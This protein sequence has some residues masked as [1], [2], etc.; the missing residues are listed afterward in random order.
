M[1]NISKFYPQLLAVLGFVI[2]ALIYFYPVLQHN[3]AFYQ[4]DI[5]QYTGMAKE[6]NDFR[7]ATGEE[8]YWTN[9]AFG[10]MPT[11][12]MGAKY[13]HNYIKAID[14]VIRFLPRPAD[15]LF[16][17]FLG[18]FILL[19]VLKVD[20]LKAFFGALAFGLSTYLIVI[21]G[22]GHNAKAHTIAYMPLVLAGI[23]LVFRKRYIA[24]GLLT[25]LATALEINA[26]HFQMTY[27]LLFLLFFVGLYFVI[28]IVKKQEYRH[29][30]IS[31]GVFAIAGIVALGLN[32]T[33]LMAT[34]EYTNYSIRGKSELT[35]KPDNKPVTSDA[36]MDYDYI[37]Q[38][39][40]GKAESFNLLVP[41]LFGG[42]SNETG[43]KN[44][45]VYEFFTG[46]VENPAD[47]ASYAEK[48]PSYWGDQPI[49][50]APAY[51]GIVVFF[52]AVFALFADKRKIKYAFLAGA[53]LT[54]LLSW[55][56]N[57]SGLTEFFINYVP[58]YDK[59]RAVSSIQVIVELCA[60]ILA[61]MGLQTFFKIEDKKQQFTYLWQSALVVVVILLGLYAFKGTFNFEGARDA[62][63][64]RSIFGEQFQR[65][66]PG[67]LEALKQDRIAMYTGDIWRSLLYT[68][69]A[70]LVLWLFTKQK[71]TE[72]IAVVLVGVLIV[73]DLFTF[74]RNYVNA[75][76]FVSARKMEE[77]FEITPADAQIMADTTHYRVYDP[78]A[79]QQARTSYFHQAVGG[80]SAVRPRREDELFTYSFE[81]GTNEDFE[82]IFKNIDEQ[83]ISL[84]APVPV[85]DLL[86]VKYLL[87][88][89]NDGYV[90]ITNPN[91]AGP[92]WFVSSVKPVAS[93][94]EELKA[95]LKLDVKN[96]AVINNEKFPEGV[97]ETT[98]VQ[99]STATITLNSY[100]PNDLEYTSDNKN[101]GLAVFSEMY[102]AKGWN[103]Y[104]DGKLTPHYQADYT[105]RAL[106]VPA[107]KHKIQFKFEPQVVK[108]GSTITLISFI[109]FLALLGAGV[110]FERKKSQSQLA[111]NSK[112]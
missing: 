20:T 101:K 41:R 29:L 79:R 46:L 78:F 59:F 54:L 48:I 52:L 39:S 61:F 104:I 7:K 47:A 11:Y 56:K 17:Y 16:L 73:A 24:G 86:N 103:A 12:Q 112:V 37:T 27:Y 74:D 5:A 91:A 60:P 88:Q 36:A 15:Y 81:R 51:I 107:G 49:V 26:N 2:V 72:T 62:D 105:L 58:L 14:G 34:A 43:G 21:L 89:N 90:T 111:V 57:F 97:A 82:P 32:A 95:T 55:G 1:K 68:L 99:D 30:G 31:L 109:I 10:G 94:D 44:S 80:Y 96:V 71:V 110:W 98:F 19:R 77:P 92:A 50:E 64:A 106:L 76:D 100:E 6:Q 83:T 4:S 33:S 67:F 63:Y 84:K 28:K 102:Y 66:G 9:S 8:P 35:F 40:Y 42:G 70:A 25:L 3:K 22:A 108:T 13:P 38:Y 69:A 45:N 75:D 93:A 23:I 87:L 85:L 18:F 65:Y 53:L